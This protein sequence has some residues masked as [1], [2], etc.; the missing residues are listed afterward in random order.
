MRPRAPQP[1]RFAGAT[2]PVRAR[3][4]DAE[5]VGA[6]GVCVTSTG[7]PS[8]SFT[9]NPASASAVTRCYSL[10]LV[11]PV[12]PVAARADVA[13]LEGGYEQKNNRPQPGRAKREFE[14]T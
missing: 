7:Y 12:P 14:G 5:W 2:T 9:P 6:T 10:L 11:G 8:V 3:S 13:T 1:R 4:G